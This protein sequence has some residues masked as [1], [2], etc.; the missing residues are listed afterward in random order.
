M[1]ARIE[2]DAGIR[3]R[4]DDYAKVRWLAVTI[5]DII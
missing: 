2:G 1:N 5:F 4:N 3:I